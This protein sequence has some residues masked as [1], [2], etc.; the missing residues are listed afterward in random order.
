MEQGVKPPDLASLRVNSRPKVRTTTD[1]GTV[2]RT[3]VA[4]RNWFSRPRPHSGS[5][6]V[7]QEFR[8]KVSG[9]LARASSS[10]EPRTPLDRN[11]HHTYTY[12]RWNR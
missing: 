5:F 3:M 6:D 2:L 11:G 9:R 4:R 8:N 1:Q 12:G 10:V 7:G